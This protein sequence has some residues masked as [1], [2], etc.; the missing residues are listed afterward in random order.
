MYSVR[1]N[2]VRTLPY[3]F[4]IW[5]DSIVVAQTFDRVLVS[6]ADS[7]VTESELLDGTLT[8]DVC[9]LLFTPPP[10]IVSS[11]SKQIIPSCLHC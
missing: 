10:L 7:D 11:S 2:S 4:G 5:S 6:Y 1:N 9:C 3:Q 8:F